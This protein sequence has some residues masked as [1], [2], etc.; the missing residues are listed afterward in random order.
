MNV[1]LS[2]SIDGSKHFVAGTTNE[3]YSFL[4]K[5][6]LPVWSCR[7][8]YGR[9][10]LLESWLYVTPTKVAF[11]LSVVEEGELLLHLPAWQLLFWGFLV[12]LTS[13]HQTKLNVARAF[14]L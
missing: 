9:V 1:V 7:V 10:L 14:L 4:A 5:N 12:P 2:T 8:Q 13:D 11:A 6:I 3:N